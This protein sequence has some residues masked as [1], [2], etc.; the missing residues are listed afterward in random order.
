MKYFGQNFRQMS[1]DELSE[2]I[3]VVYYIV[4][5]NTRG[6]IVKNSEVTRCMVWAKV[7]PI[8]GKI[9]DSAPVKTN[10]IT[11]RITIRY[12]TDILP[13]DEIVWRGRRLKITTPP[14]DIE[15]RKCW[16]QFECKE[17]VQDGNACT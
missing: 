12:R 17:A 5:R 4:E 10:E 6:D 7:L 8:T 14:I 1:T 15:S 3:S 9:N 11:Y 2:K 13:D 16:L